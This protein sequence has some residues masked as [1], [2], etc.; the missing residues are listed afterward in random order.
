MHAASLTALVTDLRRLIEMADDDNE[1]FNSLTAL[2]KFNNGH[3]KSEKQARFMLDRLK[4]FPP[5]QTAQAWADKEGLQGRAYSQLVTLGYGKTDPSKVRYAARVV[6]VDNGG[7]G[8]VGSVKV[9]HATK[10]DPTTSLDWSTVKPK[11]V[12][13]IE[14]VLKL[15]LESELQSKVLKNQPDIN[16][17]KSIPGWQDR[18]ILVSFLAQLEDG[19]PLSDKQRLI[20][21][22][23][24]P[25]KEVFVGDKAQ[26]TKTW[27]EYKEI[28]AAFATIEAAMA[29]EREAQRYQRYQQVL[30]SG[31]KWYETNPS[32][33]EKLRDSLNRYV[34]SIRDE[35][36]VRGN[37]FV[38][39]VLNDFID[40]SGARRSYPQGMGAGDVDVA[41]ATYMEKLLAGKKVTKVAFE[42]VTFVTKLVAATRHKSKAQMEAWLTAK[43]KK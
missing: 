42:V 15:D 6:V 41:I 21:Q 2:A 18:D 37:W 11:F 35:G 13:S 7:V 34:Q 30:A 19:K 29:V 28:L 17:I 4:T 27:D 16:L 8:Y 10:D 32:E 38:T 14:P 33:P 25:Q 22:K 20:L 9:K 36:H 12:R 39:M 31:Q 40:M 1:L 3:W 23:F 26:W 24:L 5:N 43:F